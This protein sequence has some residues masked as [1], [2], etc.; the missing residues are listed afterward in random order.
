MV[1]PLKNLQKTPNPNKPMISQGGIDTEKSGPHVKC[2]KH[3]T[4]RMNCVSKCNTMVLTDPKDKAAAER[5]KRKYGQNDDRI[6]VDG[7]RE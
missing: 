1:L 7:K 2:S 5:W 4:C 3:G 6:R